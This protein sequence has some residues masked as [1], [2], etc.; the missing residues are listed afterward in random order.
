MNRLSNLAAGTPSVM[1]FVQWRLKPSEHVK[2][3][4]FHFR[5]ARWRDGGLRVIPRANAFNCLRL[6]FISLLLR[7]LLDMVLVFC[8]FFRIYYS[9]GL[10]YHTGLVLPT[11]SSKHERLS[12]LSCQLSHYYSTG[13]YKEIW[14]TQGYVITLEHGLGHEKCISLNWSVLY[15][16]KKK[17]S[18]LNV[19]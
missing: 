5:C 14:H 11:A 19:K 17:N 16:E 12:A 18:V 15:I 9:S 2:A 1:H 13:E 4:V 7:V 6:H 8:F 3:A 10:H